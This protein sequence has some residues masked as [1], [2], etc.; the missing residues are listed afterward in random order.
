MVLALALAAARCGSTGNGPRDAGSDADGGRVPADAGREDGGPVTDGGL[1]DGGPGDAGTSDAGASPDAGQP[2]LGGGDWLQYRHDLL[3]TSENPGRLD[4]TSAANLTPGWTVSD[5]RLGPRGSF[6][7]FSQPVVTADTVYLT[8]AVGARVIALDAATGN[9]RWSRT[10]DGSVETDCAPLAHLGF[11]ASPALADGV[12]YVPAVDG[13]VYALDPATGATLWNTQVADPTAAGRGQFIESSPVVSSR[14]GKLYV[15]IASAEA[16][17]EIDGRVAAVD[18][19]THSVTFSDLTDPDGHT[20]AVWTSVSVD[21]DAASI[22]VTTGTG[23]QL[24]ILS[25]TSLGQAIVRMNSGDL[26]VLDHWQNPCPLTD[27]D[28]GGSPTLFAAGG[29]RMVAATAKDGF[30]YVWNRDALSSGPLWKYSLGVLDPAHPTQGNDAS[31]GWGTLV[32][33]TFANGTLF[34]AGGRTLEGWLGSV[35]AFE[36]STGRVKWRTERPGYVL[37]PIAAIGQVLI[38]ASNAP[39]NSKSWLELLSQDDGRMLSRFNGTSATWGAP[40]IA[41]GRVIWGE[42]SGRVTELQLP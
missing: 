28:F 38:V 6:Y 11:W 5:D 40:A 4:A 42:F 41:H 23:H 27:C 37:A 18:L 32:T 31:A 13:R 36:P 2:P 3:G 25:P 24:P 9:V 10:F 19:A 39:D 17:S 7:L 30:L 14:L 33:P 12:L 26:S 15:G 8:T 20:G 16:C 1:G 34:A 29:V 22:F 21:E 35:V